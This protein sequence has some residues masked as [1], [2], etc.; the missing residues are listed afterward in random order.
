M[1]IRIPPGNHSKRLF[2]LWILIFCAPTPSILANSFYAD[3]LNDPRAV[4][5]S[6]SGG[7]DTVA[8]QG[9]VDKVQATT[10]QG[11]V[12]LAPGQYHVSGTIYIWPGIRL[13]GCGAE[14]PVIILPGNTPGF[15]DA[16]HEKV[17]IFFAGRRP[18]HDQRDRQDDFH[19]GR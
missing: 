9:A 4:H 12:L 7:D 15:G 1:Q 19:Y 8:L 14:R 2:A 3:E 11:I 13:I 10:R 16:S 6:P 17:M 18:R 5:L